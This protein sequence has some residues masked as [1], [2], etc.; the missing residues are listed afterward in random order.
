MKRKNVVTALVGFILFS[1][2]IF[3]PR[4]SSAGNDSQPQ[5]LKSVIASLQDSL[6]DVEQQLN[7]LKQQSPGL[8]EYM[9]TIQLHA[10]KLW[11][12]AQDSNWDLASYELDELS[13]TI[14]AARALHFFKNGLDVSGVLESL[15]ETQLAQMRQAITSKAILPFRAAY[16]ETLD[17]CNG[18]HRSAGYEFISIITPTA[19]P[20]TN[21]RWDVPK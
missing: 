1:A 18:C 4:I 19:P 15:Q 16:G 11:F 9:T 3:L 7:Q 12:A 21:Q 2:I 14:D 13:E 8:G 10:A 5:D 6:R 20:V 17:A